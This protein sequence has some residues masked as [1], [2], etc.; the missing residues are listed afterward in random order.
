MWPPVRV[1]LVRQPLG[2]LPQVPRERHV[3]STSLS[4]GSFG[5]GAVSLPEQGLDSQVEG[6]ARL[7]DYTTCS[8][9][10]RAG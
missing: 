7:A 1:L 10:A 9:R 2:C 6:G 8:C 3:A 4:V 5:E